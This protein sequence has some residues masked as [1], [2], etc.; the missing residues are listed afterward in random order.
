MGR[1]AFSNFQPAPIT[2][3]LG[4]TYPT[5]E[6]A[7]QAMKHLAAH[8]RGAFVRAVLPLVE[9]EMRALDDAADHLGHDWYRQQADTCHGLVHD[10]E[11]LIT[12]T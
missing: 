2:C 11:N 4:I 1:F 6:H 5:L 3:D 10:L 7:F 12:P 8:L 9:Q